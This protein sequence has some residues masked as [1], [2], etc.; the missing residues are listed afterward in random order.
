[1]NRRVNRTIF[2]FKRSNNAKS[3]AMNVHV[4]YFPAAV[5]FVCP[6]C[7]ADVIIIFISLIICP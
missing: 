1:M 4:V 6:H 3:V 7:G 2:P 5:H